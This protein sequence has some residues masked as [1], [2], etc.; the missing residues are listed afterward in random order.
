MNPKSEW[1]WK[2]AASKD[3]ERDAISCDVGRDVVVADL[4]GIVAS[5]CEVVRRR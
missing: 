1:G 5:N 3:K 2:D 4:I